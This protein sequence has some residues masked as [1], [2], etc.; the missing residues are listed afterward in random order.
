VTTTPQEFDKF[1][2]DEAV[3]WTKVYKESGI[4]LD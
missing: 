3:R 2:R 1:F 4:K